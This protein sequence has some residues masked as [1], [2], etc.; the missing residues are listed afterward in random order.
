[1]S[2]RGDAGDALVE[3]TAPAPTLTPANGGANGHGANGNRVH[4]ASQGQSSRLRLD[5]KVSYAVPEK[6]CGRYR[7]GS[8]SDLDS[9][10]EDFGEGPASTARRV[11]LQAAAAPGRSSRT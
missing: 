1:M 3:M 11:C 8:A 10:G 2:P 9:A 4:G 7:E 5:F 6:K